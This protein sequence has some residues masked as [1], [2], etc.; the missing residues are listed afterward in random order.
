[1]IERKTNGCFLSP[2]ASPLFYLLCTVLLALSGCTEETRVLPVH[3]FR[4]TQ[5]PV[6]NAA[7]SDD[8][9]L[10]AFIFDDSS[11]SVW[12]VDEKRERYKWHSDV[13]DEESLHLITFSKDKAWLALTGY[14]STT[15]INLQSGDVVGS[16]HFSVKIPAPQRHQLPYPTMVTAH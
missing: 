6:R 9:R 13:L 11:V 16:W 7:L 5:E 1:M 4:F 15:L 12:D 14:W 10:A 8:A 2:L 3:E